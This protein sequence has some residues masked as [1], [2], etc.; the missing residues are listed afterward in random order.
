MPSVILTGPRTEANKL[1]NRTTQYTNAMHK[2]EIYCFDDS[3]SFGE[4][5]TLD[6]DSWEPIDYTIDNQKRINLGRSKNLKEVRVYIQRG[7]LGTYELE[8]HYIHFDRKEW[9]ELRR[10]RGKNRGLPLTIN[11]NGTIWMGDRFDN[12]IFKIFIRKNNES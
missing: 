2:K 11:T 6:L 8:S 7:K 10:V 9:A 1:Y 4:Y 12:S 3:Q 5:I